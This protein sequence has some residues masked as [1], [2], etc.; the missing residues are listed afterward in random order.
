[1]NLN[2]VPL[3]L[4]IGMNTMAGVAFLGSVAMT[5]VMAIRS[6]STPVKFFF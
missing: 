2:G 6:G 5:V 1:M 3:G 4:L